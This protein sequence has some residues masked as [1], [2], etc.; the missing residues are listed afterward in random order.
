M[1]NQE[2]IDR[3]TEQLRN[4]HEQHLIDQLAS[5]AKDRRMATESKRRARAEL[6]AK[7]V[8]MM[9]CRVSALGL[10]V[11][12]RDIWEPARYAA[13]F[14]SSW[15]HR[16]AEYAATLSIVEAWF[17]ICAALVLP[18]I[19]VLLAAPGHRFC[20]KAQDLALGGLIG[21]AIGH[22]YLYTAANRLDIPH[23]ADNYLMNCVAL[24]LSA[25]VVASWHN[26]RVR[27]FA[28][29]Q[30]EGLGQRCSTAAP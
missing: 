8:S 7:G 26:L 12:V 14:P 15:A 24:A 21:G 20:A 27:R 23:I 2:T 4:L 29:I 19:I 10:C 3:L 22:G 17:T 28:A 11:M 6:T 30:R 9:L 13:M 5:L 1:D 25:V 18:L 16:L